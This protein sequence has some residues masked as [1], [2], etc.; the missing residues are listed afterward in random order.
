MKLLLPLSELRMDRT[1][2]NLLVGATT[3]E[4]KMGS[5]ARDPKALK[6]YKRSRA[7]QRVKHHAVNLAKGTLKGAAIGGVAGAA[8]TSGMPVSARHRMLK[9]TMTLGAAGGAISQAK[10]VSRWHSSRMHMRAVNKAY[11]KQLDREYE[12]SLKGKMTRED[13]IEALMGKLS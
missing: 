2:R 5:V 9:R 10:P 11:G 3:K 12:K 13:V 7:F 6:Q 4:A 1:K 8:I